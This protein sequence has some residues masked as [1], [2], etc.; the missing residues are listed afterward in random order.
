MAEQKGNTCRWGGAVVGFFQPRLTVRIN[1]F[2]YSKRV[3][4]V[5]HA[6]N[7]VQTFRC[8]LMF[9]HT[10]LARMTNSCRLPGPRDERRK[11]VSMNQHRT[12][13]HVLLQKVRSCCWLSK[14]WPRKNADSAKHY[15]TAWDKT[16]R[17]CVLMIAADKQG[18]G[19]IKECLQSST[20]AQVAQASSFQETY[21]WLKYPETFP[22]QTPLFAH[23]TR[24]FPRRDYVFIMTRLLR[25]KEKK[26]G[27]RFEDK[28]MKK[29]FCFWKHYNPPS[30]NCLL[31]SRE[32][33]SSKCRRKLNCATHTDRVREFQTSTYKFL[34]RSLFQFLRNCWAIVAD[35]SSSFKFHRS[36]STRGRL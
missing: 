19:S 21:Y 8:N 18:G 20:A 11:H 10:A 7:W 13:K 16:K 9:Q 1:A 14:T 17:R 32:D 33:E 4:K 22:S 24:D 26:C 5:N 27:E 29:H 12:R 31:V 25:D 30:I 34:A 15:H 2:N 6:E 36:A 23:K 28:A 35:L 3:T